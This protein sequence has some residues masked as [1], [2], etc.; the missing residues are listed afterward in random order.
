MNNR[1]FTLLLVLI[2]LSLAV[3]AMKKFLIPFNGL[4]AILVYDGM[5]IFYFLRA[6][7]AEK[8]VTIPGG[9]SFRFDLSSIAYAVCSI[10]ILYR[11]QDWQ[12]WEGWITVAGFLFFIVTT[13]TLLS[14]YYLSKQPDFRFKVVNLLKGNVSWIYFLLLFPPVAFTD[15]R[16]FHNLFNG[17][18]YEEYVRSRYPF[19]EGSE[20]LE[21]YRPANRE[22]EKE[23]ERLLSK[24]MEAELKED[25]EEALRLYNQSVD[26]N[27]LNA[28][29]LF[30][31]GSLKLLKLDLNRDRA[32]SAYYDFTRAIQLDSSM[33]AAYY[34]RAVAHSY[35]YPKNRLP[36]RQDFIKAQSLDSALKQDRH[37][38]EFMKLPPVD[39]SVDTTDYEHFDD[40]E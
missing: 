20:L 29:A 24:A 15:S 27:P 8:S 33:A 14:L 16:T 2:M 13:L 17:T 18:T 19:E 25:F 10:A 28:E 22:S 39:T 26:L 4:A 12:G 40:P 6:F 11:L 38:E 23:S 35:L 3:L 37:I 34:N 1:N 30:R 7:S 9:R 32:Q 21:K 31:R 36:A 5:A